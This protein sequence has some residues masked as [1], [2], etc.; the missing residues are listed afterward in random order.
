MEGSAD[1]AS[2]NAKR[3]K[4]LVIDDRCFCRECVVRLLRDTLPNHVFV[5]IARA[6]DL[7]SSDL[8]SGDSNPFDVVILCSGATQLPDDRVAADIDYIRSRFSDTPI[9][10]LS[11]WEDSSQVGEAL[12][13]G[14][15]GFIPTTLV[16]GVVKEAVRLVAAGGT[17]IPASALVDALGGVWHSGGEGRRRDDSQV[18]DL[19]PREVDVLRLLREGRPNKIIA[20][21]LDLKETTVK[22]HVR[23][24]MKK[25]KAANRTEAALMAERALGQ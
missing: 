12:H 1:D 20:H 14:V 4:I 10:L 24:I 25:L 23:H 6:Q 16:P 3:K 5:A 19:T 15:R 22:I 8:T 21:E 9:I 2:Y 18:A 11:D 7:P 17:F 13:Y